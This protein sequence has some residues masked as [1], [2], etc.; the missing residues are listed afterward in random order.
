MS[1]SWIAWKPRMEEPSKPNPSS[2]LLSVTSCVGTEKCCHRPGMSMKRRSTILMSL[3]LMS[4]NTSA[5][6]RMWFGVS[7]ERGVRAKKRAQITAQRPRASTRRSAL[8]S[9]SD[10]SADAKVGRVRRRMV[11]V[12]ALAAALAG[13]VPRARES[14]PPAPA[15][16]SSPVPVDGP[17]PEQATAPEPS[18]SPTPLPDC[19]SRP[20]DPAE[21]DTLLRLAWRTLSGHLTGNPIRD[22]DLEGYT[23]TP[24]LM[25]PRGLF[26]TIKK[27]EQVRGLQGEI[28]PSRPLYQQG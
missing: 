3:S 10:D 26:V 18:P 20:L 24:C 28:E 22:A 4:F 13:G 9:L 25:S 19:P 11:P 27:G 12:L 5:G 17:S 1:L 2:K 7:F 14:A 16:E 6:F 15:P 21:R 8:P 23:F